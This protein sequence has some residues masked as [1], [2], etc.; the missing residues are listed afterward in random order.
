MAI[1]L[2]LLD[3]YHDGQVIPEKK[4]KKKAFK[5][6][7]KSQKKSPY[8]AERKSATAASKVSQLQHSDTLIS[9]A[10]NQPKISLHSNSINTELNFR[11]LGARKKN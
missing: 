9:T 3:G 1:S 4:E 10:R 5:R 7:K 6:L 2:A 8:A 11:G